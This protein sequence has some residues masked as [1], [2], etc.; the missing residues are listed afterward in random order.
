MPI[1]DSLPALTARIAYNKARVALRRNFWPLAGGVTT[2]QLTEPSRYVFGTAADV[3]MYSSK[4]NPL[5]NSVVRAC[6]RS[7]RNPMIRAE[8]AVWQG[9]SQQLATHPLV[10]LIL[11]P[12]PG[13]T[14]S[15]F[16]GQMVESFIGT[17]E[18]IYEIE[19]D[20]GLPVKL[21][22]IPTSAVKVSEDGDRYRISQRRKAGH[23]VLP[24]EQVLHLRYQFGLGNGLRGQ[25]AFTGL[26]RDEIALYHRVVRLLSGYMAN[27]GSPGLAIMPESKSNGASEFT[28]E[29]LAIAGKLVDSFTN[30]REGLAVTF[31]RPVQIMQLKSAFERQGIAEFL[32]P[33]AASICAVLGVPPSIAL[34]DA[35]GP[36]T[37]WGDT[38]AESRAEFYSNT[39]IPNLRNIAEQI[40]QQ[41]LQRFF[42]PESVTR[43][44]WVYPEPPQYL[45]EAPPVDA[46]D[47]APP[48]SE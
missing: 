24:A 11:N 22:Y 16:I 41:L 15:L 31:N 26:V 2:E 20:K 25:S 36:T 3:E 39:I 14:H 18:A 13:C 17:G 1:R 44:D 40:D 7:I 47:N 19:L 34:V 28:E 27:R 30:G 6:L 37:I 38:Q 45:A 21:L 33:P 9:D 43:F 32:K 12:C 42:D 8:P 4:G 46:A 48:Q 10:D 5:D 29:E 23:K 35:G